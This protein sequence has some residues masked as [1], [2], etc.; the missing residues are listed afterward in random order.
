MVEA[1]SIDIDKLDVLHK[2]MFE[3][4]K[5]HGVHHIC[6]KTGRSF[7][8]TYLWAVKKVDLDLVSRLCL[9]DRVDV[10][11]K[12]KNGRTAMYYASCNA[13]KTLEVFQLLE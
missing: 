2:N 10:N 7:L 8:Q 5:E 9:Q 11:H 6:E 13:D 1:A 4:Y 3:I 12:A